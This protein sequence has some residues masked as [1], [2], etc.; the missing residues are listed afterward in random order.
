MLKELIEV[1]EAGLINMGAPECLFPETLIFNE[2]WLLR[3]VLME[4]KAGSDKSRFG[5]LPFPDDAKIYSEGQLYTP[6]KAR[7][8]G[9]K[10][11]ES[12]THVDGIVGHLSIVGTSSGITLDPGFT[13][14]SVF[15]AKLS[16]HLASGTTHAPGFDRVS[17]TAA[18]IIN[19]ILT[20]QPQAA[21]AAHLVVSYPRDHRTITPGQYTT[22][23]IERQIDKRLGAYL[24]TGG[25]M[26]TI[27]AF[28]AGWRDVL[29]DLKIWFITWE[30]VLAEI[31]DDELNRFYDLCK[32]FKE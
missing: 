30:D 18:C 22:D 9:D 8:R 26:D 3:T 29:Q 10:Q 23:Y 27:S 7:F 2:G 28:I 16:S 19:S 24:E 15:E 6:F 32:R 21:Y 31:A 5:F 11:A 4:W 1:Y 12:N 17:R 25:R 20:G 14:L 13:Y